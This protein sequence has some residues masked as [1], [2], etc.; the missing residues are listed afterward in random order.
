MIY[1]MNE[2]SLQENEIIFTYIHLDISKAP[3]V[4]EAHMLILFK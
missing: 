4:C 1:F 2:Q 3:T